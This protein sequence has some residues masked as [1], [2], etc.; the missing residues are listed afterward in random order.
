MKQKIIAFHKEFKKHTTVAILAAFAF[1]I[2]LAWRDFFS[3]LVNYLIKNFGLSGEVY[4]YKLI[5]A[6]L[7]TLIAVIGIIIISK[8]NVDD[9]QKNKT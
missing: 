6:V 5:S 1:L 7:I 4:L 8:I 3:D 2:A 9:K